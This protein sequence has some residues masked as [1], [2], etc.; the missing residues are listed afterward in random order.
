MSHQLRTMA[1]ETLIGP[2]VRIVMTVTV[3]SLLLWSVVSMAWLTLAC[4]SYPWLC[5]I[6]AV[7]TNGVAGIATWFSM[8]ERVDLA[9]RRYAVVVAATG[10]IMDVIATGGQHYLALEYPGITPTSIHPDP[11]WGWVVGGLPSLM[12]GLLGH[13]IFRIW[14]Q[15]RR[16]RIAA[17]QKQI[18]VAEQQ[19]IADAAAQERAHEEARIAAEREF[20]RTANETAA[21]ADEAAARRIAAEAEAE[22]QRAERAKAEAAKLKAEQRAMRSIEQSEPGL[23]RRSKA[24]RGPGPARG[25]APAQSGGLDVSELVDTAKKVA[26]QLARSGERLNRRNL[27]GGIRSAGVTCSTDRA[28]ALLKVLEGEGFGPDQTAADRPPLRAVVR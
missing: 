3:A 5:W 19:R 26:E 4:W 9:T 21:R 24:G 14:A 1:S 10:V 22:R 15:V 17:Q 8:M 27:L 20:Q 18:E 7:A 25:S 12:A 11:R 16:D 23:Q 2:W 13:V 28:S 6:P